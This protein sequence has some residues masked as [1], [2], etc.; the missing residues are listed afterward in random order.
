MLIASAI[1]CEGKNRQHRTE[2]VKSKVFRLPQP[3]KNRRHNIGLMAQYWIKIWNGKE[4]VLR[5]SEVDIIDYHYP[6]I[7]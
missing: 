1:S 5:R 7:M 6:F 2:K 3:K 4:M